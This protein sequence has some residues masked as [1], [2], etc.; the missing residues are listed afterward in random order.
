MDWG[1]SSI[2]DTVR[3]AQTGQK[4]LLAARDR[5]AAQSWHSL[6]GRQSRC[7]E[8][9]GAEARNA[10]EQPTM[11]RTALTGKNNAA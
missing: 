10:V 3:Q 11:H 8:S 5:E 1:M 6:C 9:C 2:Q 4:R 7:W